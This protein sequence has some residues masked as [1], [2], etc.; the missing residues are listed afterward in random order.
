MAVAMAIGCLTAQV[1]ATVGFNLTRRYK[2]AYEVRERQGEKPPLSILRIVAQFIV[3]TSA[4]YAP[5][6][7]FG[8]WKMVYYLDNVENY[9]ALVFGC[10]A[11]FAT[12]AFATAISVYLIGRIGN[13]TGSFLAALGG[14]ILGGAG[15]GVSGCLFASMMWAMYSNGPDEPGSVLPTIIIFISV[16]AAPAACATIGFNLTRR[17]ISLPGG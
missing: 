12:I 9:G 17:Y 14:S 4:A 11:I 16:F 2:P 15:F 6:S 8:I 3:A 10:F 13:Q 7:A 5:V 1:G